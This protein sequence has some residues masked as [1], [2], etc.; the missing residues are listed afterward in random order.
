MVKG[1]WEAGIEVQVVQ[2]ELIY[3]LKDADM[4]LTRLTLADDMSENFSF[5][6]QPMRQFRVRGL[7]S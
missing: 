5:A 6:K 7:I 3:R 1:P 4:A 2:L